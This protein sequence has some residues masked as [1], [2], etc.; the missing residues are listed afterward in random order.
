MQARPYQLTTVNSIKPKQ[1]NLCILPQRSGKS[2][3]MFLAIQKFKFKKTLIIVGYRKIVE[4]LA[5]Y[6]PDHTH[7]LSGKPF[8]NDAQVHLA[9]FQ[10]LVNRDIDLSQYDCIIQDE[11]HS[12][13]SKSA[14]DIVF[15]LNATVLLFTGTPLSN[16][17]KLLTKGIDN[18]IQPISV[19]EL[20]DNKWLAPTRFM[21]NSNIIGSNAE[22]LQTNKSDFDESV[23]RQLIQKEHLL[24]E[25]LDL[26]ERDKLDTEHKT[27]I[28]V[29]YIATAEELYELIKHRTN[30]FIV[31]SKLSNKQ[32]TD[33]IAT[34][35]AAES[36][37]LINVRA[38]SLGFNSKTTDRLI[39]AFFT[40]IHSLCLQI[41]W[42]ASTINPAD[43]NKVAT[44]YDMTGQLSTINPYSDF[45]HYS[46]K[47]P[48]REQCKKQFPTDQLQQYFCMEGC[49]GE[50]ILVPCKGELPYSLAKNEFI[51][52]FSVH[53]GKPCGESRP[54][55]EFTYKTT[56]PSLG[57]VTKWS[58]CQ[59]GCITKYDVRTMVDPS[60]MISVYDS[61][62]ILN[63]VTILYS[64]EHRKA[65]ALFDD[66]SK[67]QYKMLMFDS[68][69]ELY[70]QAVKFFNGKQFQMVSNVR[71][72]KLPNVSVEPGLHD[73]VSL[74]NW[75]EGSNQSFIRKLVKAKLAHIVDY[76][77]MKPGFT[78]YQMKLVNTQNQKKTLQFL[79]QHNID[80]ADLIKFFNKL[81]E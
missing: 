67:P 7:I 22:T 3:I 12:R 9:S 70:K 16:S 23:V 55:W 38:L 57:V 33:T 19:K 43:P 37:V 71:M 50:P 73:A 40:K 30:V 46:K 45:K 69:E 52:N 28:Y 2:Y 10:T 17:N 58:K 51:S 4:Q 75:L 25:I 8:N 34:Y 6:F 13:T 66:T 18:F 60:E 63:T 41:L 78:Y 64:S 26:I 74:V 31:H 44:V 27:L 42:R 81:K 61:G 21:S 11:Y 1:V 62:A 24:Q 29:N 32:Q 35:Q 5:D 65:F 49:T 56:E 14:T 72:P 54:V 20:I 68:S 48:C 36:G 76:L 59:C 80:R 47:L 77:G 39:Y 15:Q 79:N 53:S